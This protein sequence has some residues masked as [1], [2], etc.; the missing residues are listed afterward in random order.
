MSFE[1]T[2]LSRCQAT[3]ETL[4]STQPEESLYSVFQFATMSYYV[5]LNDVND[6]GCFDTSTGMCF[7]LSI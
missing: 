6:V 2:F 7:V 3:V 5:P 4:N 1:I